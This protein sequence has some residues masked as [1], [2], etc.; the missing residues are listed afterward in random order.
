[1][2]NFKL[3][4]VILGLAVAAGCATK[5]KLM[6]VPMV[7][8][9]K[10]NSGDYELKEMG[11]ISGKFCADVTEDEGNMG[12]IDMSVMNAQKQSGADFI[13][14]VSVWAEAG[15]CTS[16]EGTGMKIVKSK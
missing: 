2:K 13:S 8:M 15:G 6:D 4:L 3:A 16:I 11:P 5:R 12:L 14:N 9:T 10:Y 7:S 1:M